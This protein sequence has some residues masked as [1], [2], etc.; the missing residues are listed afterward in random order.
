[1]AFGFSSLSFADVNCINQTAEKQICVNDKVYS[2]FPLFVVPHTVERISDSG[3]VYFAHH[4]S[5][6]GMRLNAHQKEDV[7]IA[8]GCLSGFCVNSM[9]YSTA[10]S[11]PDG[12]KVVAIN[13]AKEKIL[14]K[15]GNRV[16]K[17]DAEDL[18]IVPQP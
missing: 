7:Y 13:F 12:A 14:V 2:G 10:H 6:N 11:Y 15:D 9:V 5:E 4:V 8:S 18:I 3:K 16:R 1:M 17:E